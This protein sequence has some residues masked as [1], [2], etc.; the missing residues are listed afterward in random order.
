MDHTFEQASDYVKIGGHIYIGELHPFKQYTGSKAR[1]EAANGRTQI[2]ECFTHHI[3]DFVQ[4]AKKYGLTPI[5]INEHLN[6]D[7][8]LNPKNPHY[9]F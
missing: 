6:D 7:K 1:F 2:L 8:K 9:P 3:S 4:S 5:N